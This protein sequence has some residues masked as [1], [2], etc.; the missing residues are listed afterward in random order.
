MTVGLTEDNFNP[1]LTRP[2][3]GLN[4][5]VKMLNCNEYS[6][7]VTPWDPTRTGAQHLQ[8]Y[9][10]LTE[11][12]KRRSPGDWNFINPGTNANQVAIG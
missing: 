12:D 6:L 4:C 7:K 10:K 1:A 2:T 3:T 5:Q 11:R 9:H 8:I